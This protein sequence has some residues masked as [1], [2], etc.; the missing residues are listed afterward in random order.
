MKERKQ[1]FFVDKEIRLLDAIFEFKG[2]LSKKSIKILI[3]NMM[4]KVNDTVVTNNN[5]L[6]SNKDLVEICYEKRAV[7]TGLPE[8]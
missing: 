5:Y 1:A 6:L 4:I 8:Y 2:D 7:S 3:K